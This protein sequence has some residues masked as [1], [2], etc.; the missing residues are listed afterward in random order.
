MSFKKLSFL[1]QVKVML[2]FFFNLLNNNDFIN[3][4]KISIL[5]DTIGD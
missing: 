1:I 5:K 2:S 4:S 3:Q